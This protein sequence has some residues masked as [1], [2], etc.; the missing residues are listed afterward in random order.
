MLLILMCP[1][2]NPLQKRYLNDQILIMVAIWSSPN[3]KFFFC[4]SF[5]KFYSQG[6][7]VEGQENIQE[8]LTKQLV[9]C[10]YLC[11]L[12]ILCKGS[13]CILYVYVCYFCI[14]LGGNFVC[15]V[16]DMFTP[17]SI[18][19]FYLLYRCFNRVC[20]FKPVTSRPAN[21][22]RFGT[23][24]C[25]STSFCLCRYVICECLLEQD[26]AVVEYLSAVNLKLIELKDSSHDVINVSDYC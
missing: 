3:N 11:A 12:S 14:T 20:L 9:L 1:S 13:T 5:K 4:S 2:S 18:G 21:S 24:Y 17:F 23:K 25:S 26:C 6:I 22:E 16:F 15:K 7:S 8:I 10:Q 19:L